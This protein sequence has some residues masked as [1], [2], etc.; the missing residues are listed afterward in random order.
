VKRTV[1]VLS[2]ILLALGGGFGAGWLA[3]RP[4]P[5]PRSPNG[6]YPTPTA[7]AIVDIPAPCECPARVKVPG[8]VGVRLARAETILRR[9]G[10]RR[11]VVSGNVLSSQGDHVLDQSPSPG[12]FVD[13]GVR[14]TIFIP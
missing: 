5:S 7:S 12:V 13:P 14:V 4:A 10:F 9:A 8:V 2:A 1:L 11:F 6:P 3:R